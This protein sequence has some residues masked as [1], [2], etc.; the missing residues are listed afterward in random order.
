MKKRS[1]KSIIVLIATIFLVAGIFTAFQSTP[2]QEIVPIS[3]VADEI[4]SDNVK[5]IEVS[6]NKVD[7][8]LKDGS[9]Q[10]SEYNQS[11]P[12]T[13]TL[14]D[15][16][17][18]P[19][20]VSSIDIKESSDSSTWIAIAINVIPI[21]LIVGFFYFMLKQ[22][23]GSSNQAKMFGRSKAKLF[24]P[25][26]KKITFR[27][28]A[29]V[30]EAK[31]ELN[32]IVEFLKHPKKFL[33]LGAKIPKGVLLFGPPGT[34][35]TLL[36]RAVAGEANVPF[37]SISGSEFVE[38]FVGVG[39]SRVRDLFLKAKKNAPSIIFIDEIDAVGRQRGSGLGGSH[40]EREQT[41]NQ[42]LV[43]MDGFEQGTNVIVIA[44][45]NRPDVL[46]PALLRPGR[47]DR[48]VVLDMPDIKDRIEILKVHAKNKPL[49]KET[50][51]ETIAKKTPGFSGA[52]LE[53][54]LNEAA[55]FAARNNRKEVTKIDLDEAVEKVL[56]GPERKSKILSPKEKEITAYHEAG[57]AL[58]GHLLPHTDPIHKISIIARGMAGGVTW[59][60]P[61]EDK[62]MISKSELEDNLAMSLGGRAAEK[63][64]FNEITTG[65]ESDLRKA[66]KMARQMVTEYGMSEALG[67]RVFG[68]KEE[69]VFLGR[70]L[71]EHKD[72]SDQTAYKIDEEVG[73]IISEAMK[74]ANDVI[75]KHKERLTQI[76]KKLLKE[77]VIE[78]DAFEALFKLAEANGENAA[79]GA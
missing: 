55:I 62:H 32:E 4:K 47:F 8:T 75:T 16:G 40:D 25:N 64:M 72:Y 36:A 1:P 57:H 23:Q 51:L 49:A 77:E 39:A 61:Q 37:F 63:I 33:N 52:D 35:K 3:K 68:H 53:N 76:A 19:A 78:G 48:R 54:L 65:A 24:E 14:K 26:V 18:D 6:G 58:V 69:L 45:T 43:E 29:G 34:G 59:S 56:L 20:K 42:I 7:I 67:S 50:N 11:Q 2:K 27:D 79:A 21:F 38:M 60:L 70:E 17:A 9:K 31:E 12:I 44:G 5:G 74:K 15:L 30:K 46:D 13:T 71:G 73:K 10:T 22:A 41:L 28:V 66:T